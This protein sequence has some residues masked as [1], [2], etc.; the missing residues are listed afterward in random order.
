[1]KTNTNVTTNFVDIFGNGAT[2]R[3]K[4]GVRY[5]ILR[6][7]DPKKRIFTVLRI[8]AVSV[9]YNVEVETRSSVDLMKL[10]YIGTAEVNLDI[11]I[12]DTTGQG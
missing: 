12:T 8:F 4:T 11:K 10:E 3:D 5:I 9:G 7:S 2:F 1:M 6:E